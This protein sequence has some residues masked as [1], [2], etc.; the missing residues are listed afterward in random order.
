IDGID[1]EKIG[2][3]GM[4]PRLE[5]AL[6]KLARIHF[7]HDLAVLRA[8][9]R[10]HLAVAYRLHELVGDVDAVMEIEALAVEIARGFA[11]FEELFDL[12]MMNVEIA[13]GRAA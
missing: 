4:Q 9:K 10:E 2:L 11:D 3:A 13:R 1:E 7:A 6:P 8:A 5:D 12:G